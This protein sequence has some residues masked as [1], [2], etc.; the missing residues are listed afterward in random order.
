[1]PILWLDTERRKE[2]LSGKK[3]LR[4]LKRR[5]NLNFRKSFLSGMTMKKIRLKWVKKTFKSKKTSSK[6]KTD[7]SSKS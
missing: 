4:W 7:W 3:E 5:E 6:A 1:M 2:K